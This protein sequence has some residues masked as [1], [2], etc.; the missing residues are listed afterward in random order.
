MITSDLKTNL[1]NSFKEMI[2]HIILNSSVRLDEFHASVEDE[3]LSIEFDIPLSI[4]TLRKIE[5]FQGE[6]LLSSCKVFVPVTS[7][8]LFKYRVEVN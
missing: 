2:S 7:D 6:K 5:F 3:I 1:N 8:T 4:D